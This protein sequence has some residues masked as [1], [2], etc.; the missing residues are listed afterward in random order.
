MCTLFRAHE[1][2][3][4]ALKRTVLSAMD[5]SASFTLSNECSWM[6]GTMPCSAAKASIA[7]MDARPPDAVP[8]TVICR[9]SRSP[10]ASMTSGLPWTPAYLGGRESGDGG[11]QAP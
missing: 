6:V 3:S 1:R 4:T 2:D 5:L 9:A 11:R 8:V 7:V 10:K